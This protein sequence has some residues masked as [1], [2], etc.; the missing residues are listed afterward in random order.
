VHNSFY[1]QYVVKHNDYESFF[2][3]VSSN[4]LNLT[5]MQCTQLTTNMFRYTATT[6]E[7]NLT[8]CVSDWDVP[9][10]VQSSFFHS[11]PNR[12]TVYLIF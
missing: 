2:L 5:A 1:Y 9:V 6:L 3:H 11:I 4:V 8:V 7:Q 12:L 10:F